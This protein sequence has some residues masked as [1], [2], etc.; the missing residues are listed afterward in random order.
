MKIIEVLYPTMQFIE[1]NPL[2]KAY[3][4]K[5]FITLDPTIRRWKA[6]DNSK[7]TC[8]IEHFKERLDAERWLSW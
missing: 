6:L 1:K 4:G 3:K 8:R 7:N 2:N 5:K